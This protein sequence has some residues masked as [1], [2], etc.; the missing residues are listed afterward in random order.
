[1]RKQL[2]IWLMDVHFTDIVKE[3]G[4]SPSSCK[5]IKRFDGYVSLR[6]YCESY[7]WL[8]INKMRKSKKTI[9]YVGRFDPPLRY[10]EFS[11]LIGGESGISCIQ[12]NRLSGVVRSYKRNGIN[13]RRDI[14]ESLKDMVL[15]LHNKRLIFDVGELVQI[16]ITLKRGRNLNRIPKHILNRYGR[17]HFKNT[18]LVSANWKLIKNGESFNWMCWGEELVVLRCGKNGLFCVKYKHGCV[19]F[20][21]WDKPEFYAFQDY[22]GNLWKNPPDSDIK[23]IE[24]MIMAI[25]SENSPVV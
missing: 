13:R 2:P 21:N 18:K 11:G 3:T 6:V 16:P 15:E 20:S 14:D 25:T 23:L 7:V 5:D 1:M 4:L 24:K 9:G 12:T 19:F 22:W 17:T 8:A 10:M